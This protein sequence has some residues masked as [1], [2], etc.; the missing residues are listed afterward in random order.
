MINT[1]RKMFGLGS[2]TDY[3]MLMAQGAVVIDVRTNAE[4]AGGHIKKSINIPLDKLNSEIAK[5]KKG[6]P[7]ITCC[8]SGMRSAAAKNI[9]KSKGFEEVING[10]G[11]SSLQSKLN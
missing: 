5:I 8:A 1:I 11:W 2:P 6:V 9:L 3:K 10:G 7:V 4:Y